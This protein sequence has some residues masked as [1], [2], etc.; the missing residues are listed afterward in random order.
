MLG[1]NSKSLVKLFQN[2]TLPHLSSNILK[3]PCQ[4]L[5]ISLQ[6]KGHTKCKWDNDIFSLKY[7]LPTSLCAN[8]SLNVK[9]R[10][11]KYSRHQLQV[12]QRFLCVVLLSSPSPKWSKLVCFAYKWQC[13]YREPRLQSTPRNYAPCFSSQWVC[14]CDSTIALMFWCY[15]SLS[16]ACMYLLH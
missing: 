11:A 4:Y 12:F 16:T 9:A 15:I 1:E 8:A 5:I 7:C 13:Y 14:V 10:G 6:G 3:G 2:W